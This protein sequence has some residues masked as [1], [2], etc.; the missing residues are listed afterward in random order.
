MRGKTRASGKS[1]LVWVLLLI[2]ESIGARFF[3]QS[4][5]EFLSTLDNSTIENRSISIDDKAYK[6]SGR[7]V[8]ARDVKKGVIYD[9]SGP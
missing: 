2:G 1:T 5:S 4:Q 3:N 8:G 9:L 6:R 7:N